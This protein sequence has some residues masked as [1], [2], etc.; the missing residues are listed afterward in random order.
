MTTIEILT[1]IRDWILAK[2]T[3]RDTVLSEFLASLRQDVDNIKDGLGNV[4]DLRAR[5][6]MLDNVPDVA[7][8]PMKTIGTGA[9]S[10]S[11]IPENWD[12]DR[13]G[14]WTGVPRFIG[15][16]YYDITNK[17]RYDAFSVTNSVG[18]WVLMN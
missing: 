1:G 9:P 14:I 2:L 10:A 3:P 13:Y 7:S 15:Q 4:Y 8:A 18:D 16:E 6:A 17:K 12:S 11:I 5:K